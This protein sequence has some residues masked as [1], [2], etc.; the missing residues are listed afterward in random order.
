M[1]QKE[2]GMKTP[3]AILI[4]LVCGLG[5]SGTCLAGE[6][7]QAVVLD[8]D[9]GQYGVSAAELEGSWPKKAEAARY[10]PDARPYADFQ[11][12]D[13]RFNAIM[14]RIANNPGRHACATSDERTY[15]RDY[16]AAH[17]SMET[18]VRANDLTHTCPQSG[19][20]DGDL[21]IGLR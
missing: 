19:P 3:L 1:G 5:A 12:A 2:I 21:L 6:H 9:T 15:V 20:G 11:T 13:G 10:D 16:V 18:A 17:P 7:S 14:N 8:L 4:A